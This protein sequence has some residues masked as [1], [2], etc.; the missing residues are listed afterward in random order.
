MND[1]NEYMEF[2][3]FKNIPGIYNNGTMYLIIADRKQLDHMRAPFDGHN[4]IVWCCA[5]KAGGP[6]KRIEQVADGYTGFW[7][8]CEHLELRL[9]LKV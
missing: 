4:G 2:A 1:S 7:R 3:E 6:L 9:C 5:D 8:R